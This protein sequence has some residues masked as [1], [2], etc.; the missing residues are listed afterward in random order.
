MSATAKLE[1]Q[2]GGMACSFC[3]AS[4]S[5][6]LSR[7]RGVRDVR[8]VEVSLAQEEVLVGF[9]PREV[10]LPYSEIELLAPERG[11]NL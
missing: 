2:I 5:K 1:L 8:D 4:I 7:M 6:R 11:E 10:N 9:E 3:A